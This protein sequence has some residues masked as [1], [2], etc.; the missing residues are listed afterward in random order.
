[1][2]E[3]VLLKN[4]LSC[5]RYLVG[6]MVHLVAVS[7]SA[8]EEENRSVSGGLLAKG[9]IPEINTRREIQILAFVSIDK[10]SW[11][12]PP[13][14]AWDGGVVNWLDTRVLDLLENPKTRFD[15]NIR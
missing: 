14:P 6:L 5:L 7:G 12:W 13:F 10:G 3:S 2:D 9:R 11:I 4:H 1:M 8:T 15:Y